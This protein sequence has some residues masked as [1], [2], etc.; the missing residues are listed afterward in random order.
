MSN[1]NEGD[2][3]MATWLKLIGSATSPVTEWER[4]YV[5]FRKA[6][7]PSIRTGDHLFLYAPGGSRRIF[8][9]AEVISDPETIRITT[10]ARREVANG[11]Y[12]FV[13]RLIFRSLLAF[14]SMRFRAPET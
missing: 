5:G 8:A 2:N 14:S 10:R 13:T 6:N 12:V 11:N 3:I 1:P 9:L 4:E 7:K